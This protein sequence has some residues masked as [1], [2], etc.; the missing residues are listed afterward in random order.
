MTESP[1]DFPSPNLESTKVQG[2]AS[3]ARDN[4]APLPPG[5]EPTRHQA[6]VR[7]IAERKRIEEALQQSEEK[8]R[9]LIEMTDTGYVIIDDQ[10]RVLDANR[11]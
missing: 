5:E 4:S 3:S 7:D 6:L 10:G 8:H 1:K 11:E 2:T 9:R